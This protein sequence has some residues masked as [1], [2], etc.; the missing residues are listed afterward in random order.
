MKYFEVIKDDLI[1]AL[2]W[3][4]MLLSLVA[5]MR[6]VAWLFS[7]IELMNYASGW[8][9]AV[10]FDF[11]IFLLTLIAHKYKEGTA[12]RR[13]IRAGIYS[14]AILS[15]IANVMY[16][17]EHQVELVRVNG[18]LWL[19]IPYVFAL[20]LPLMVVFFA[21]VLSREEDVRVYIL[22]AIPAF[23]SHQAPD[24]ALRL[25]ERFAIIHSIDED[26]VQV[27]QNPG[28]YAVGHCE[29]MRM[30]APF[31]IVPIF[32]FDNLLSL[33]K[34][35]CFFGLYARAGFHGESCAPT[36][37]LTWRKLS[38]T[39]ANLPSFRRVFLSCFALEIAFKAPSKLLCFSIVLNCPV[40]SLFSLNEGFM[41]KP[42]NDEQKVELISEAKKNA[43]GKPLFLAEY[44][45]A[46]RDGSTE[47]LC[48]VFREPTAAEMQLYSEQA[49]R[50]SI[51]ASEQLL[52]GLVVVSGKDES[53]QDLL[54]QIGPHSM[55]IITWVQ[56]YLNPLFGRPLEHK[57]LVAV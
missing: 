44:S 27:V 30:L 40:L 42:L 41:N 54:E 24:F 19:L 31:E 55:A 23:F 21:E 45:F 5:S 26:S 9:A 16:G 35:D 7:T 51:G 3:L 39:L 36:F 38:I 57:P 22:P 52:R 1:R 2:L 49:Q 25:L 8:I 50:D 43:P 6:H 28:V 13:F 15:A 20:A 37:R 34:A 29:R 47:H 32:G 11:G 4:L 46:Q 53:S 18:V 56:E 10:G 12:Q 48:F 14:N 17:V 33:E